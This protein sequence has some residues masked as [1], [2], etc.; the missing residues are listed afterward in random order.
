MKKLSPGLMKKMEEVTDEDI[1]AMRKESKLEESKW[2][3]NMLEKRKLE[4]STS[5]KRPPRLMPKKQ[6]EIKKPEPTEHPVFKKKILNLK[7]TEAEQKD[8]LEKNASR[9]RTPHLKSKKSKPEPTELPLSKPKR[10]TAELIEPKQKESKIEKSTF[11]RCTLLLQLKRPEKVT[12]ESIEVIRK[13]NLIEIEESNS[14]RCT[15][16][17]KLKVIRKNLFKVRK[18]EKMKVIEARASRKSKCSSDVIV[19]E[20][21]EEDDA[22]VQEIKRAINEAQ[23]TEDQ[24]YAAFGRPDGWN[25]YSRLLALHT[26]TMKEFLGWAE[27]LKMDVLVSLVPRRKS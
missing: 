20:L 6:K 14:R 21:H 2:K 17:L 27:L 15:L 13:E 5:H 24:V 9:R 26:M 25:N 19:C 16:R 10:I 3:E 8:M 4:E 12:D 22:M 23:I 11:R 18:E 1:E 7:N